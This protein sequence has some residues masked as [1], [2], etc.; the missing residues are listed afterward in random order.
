[1]VD[2]HRSVAGLRSANKEARARYTGDA[3][4]RQRASNIL[5]P[6][7]IAGD[8][9]AG[10]ML[11]T[12]LGSDFLRPITHGDL[13]AFRA[14]VA[15]AGKA[16][17]G[18]ITAKD[19]INLSLPIDRERS[20]QQIRTAVPVQSLGGRIHFITNAGPES[21]VTRHHVHI[22][23]LSFMAA[24]S[25]P[26]KPGEASKRVATGPLKFD[27]DCGRHTYW[28][29]Y[30]ATIGNFNAGRAETGYPKIRNPQLVGV[31]CKHVLRVM[32]ALSQPFIRVQIEKMIIKARDGIQRDAKLLTIKEADALARQQEKT[33][34]H[35]R[36]TVES[37]AE[38]RTRLAQARAVKAAQEAS[39]ATPAAAT[40]AQA[41]RSRLQFAANARELAARG[42]LTPDQLKTILGT[43]K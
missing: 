19:V 24:V 16:F 41:A 40:A 23:L 32:V 33:A 3:A 14:N 12:T 35:K 42:F 25:S 7:E 43:L 34:H 31:A 11:G 15:T 4:R 26:T 38:K 27:C 10:R 9:D 30:I 17:K 5:Q 37:T 39:R 2:R 29:R 22:E 13:E 20:N 1:M 28:F 36:N 8:Y 18:G 6:H 21:E